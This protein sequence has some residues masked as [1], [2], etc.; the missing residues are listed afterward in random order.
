MTRTSRN[1]RYGA[2]A[3]IAT[4]GSE[5]PRWV[6]PPRSG[7]RPG[8]SAIRRTGAIRKAAGWC[9]PPLVGDRRKARWVWISL[10]SP[11]RKTASQPLMEQASF[12]GS[13]RLLQARFE[14][15]KQIAER[16]LGANRG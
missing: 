16:P 2:W 4:D 11:H 10:L 3:G 12:G 6:E 7:A 14:A 8:R 1:F 5:R 9:G 13:E 15:R